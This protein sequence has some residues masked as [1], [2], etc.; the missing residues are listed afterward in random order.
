M[1]IKLCIYTFN[2]GK[3]IDSNP[4]YR[5]CSDSQKSYAYK[6]GAD[7]LMRTEFHCEKQVEPVKHFNYNLM[8]DKFYIRDLLDYYDRVLY[9]DG[10]VF[11]KKNADDI[12]KELNKDFV[13]MRNEA[14]NGVEY[15][16]QIDKIKGDIE[17]TKTDSRYDFYNA[18]VILVNRNQQYLFNF[19]KEEYCYFE[20][21][22]LIC[23]QPYL[24]WI[25]QNYNVPVKEMGQKYNAMQYFNQD[26]DFLHFAN[27]HN[28]NELVKELINE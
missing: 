26:G 18:G 15:P 7:F 24:N 22:P 19:N 3:T 21:L 1:S 14:F 10:D 25:I 13:Y 17:W 4:C 6:V 5:L 27:V 20:D 16:S 23:D 28:R 2:Y 9:V 12:F 11:I 8:P